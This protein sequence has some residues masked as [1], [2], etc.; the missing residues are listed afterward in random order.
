[1][2]HMSK[3][4]A[5]DRMQ[6]WKSTLKHLATVHRQGPQKNIMIFSTAR[7]GTTWL[8]EILATQGRFKFL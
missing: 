8:G 5:A 3:R 1:M 4:L 2:T 7:S 6:R